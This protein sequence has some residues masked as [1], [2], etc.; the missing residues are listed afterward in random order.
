MLMPAEPSHE[1]LAALGVPRFR[2]G[3]LVRH[4]RYGYRGV[5]VE[6]DSVCKANEQWYKGNLTQPK[7]EQ[8]WYHVL[9]DASASTTYAA[10]EN[11]LLDESGEAIIHPL[12]EYF[13]NDF[14]GG[15]YIR[16]D[17]PW[18]GSF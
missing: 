6:A 7:R 4:K 18:P 5:I 17:I 11:L 16:N 3:Q 8:P 1:D 14:V 12:L 13:F 9:V 10:E 2:A 15:A